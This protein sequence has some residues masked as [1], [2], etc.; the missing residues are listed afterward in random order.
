MTIKEG[1]IIKKVLERSLKN[2]LEALR[3]YANPTRIKWYL[4]KKSGKLPSIFPADKIY[5]I[6]YISY[7]NKI[8]R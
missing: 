6:H 7:I 2:P 4:N 5:I 8:W 3:F 1:S